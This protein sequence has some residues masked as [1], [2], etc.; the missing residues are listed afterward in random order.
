MYI[1]IYI[2]IYICI[3]IYRA[4]NRGCSIAK[5]ESLLGKEEIANHFGKVNHKIANHL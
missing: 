2:Y 4:K 1:C 3:Y 5:C